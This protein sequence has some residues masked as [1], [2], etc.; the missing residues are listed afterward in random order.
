MPEPTQR[1]TVHG[2]DVQV[3]PDKDALGAAAAEFVAGRVREA[4]SARGEARVIFA[5]GASQYEFLAALLPAE[6]ITPAGAGYVPLT[7][8][9]AI[10][11]ALAALFGPESVDALPACPVA[12]RAATE[13][14][15]IAQHAFLGTRDDMDS[16]VASIRKVQR[17]WA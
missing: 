13:V 16:I 15:W 12:E 8:S 1:F 11:G 17:A 3:Y 7:R 6:G 9:P 4:L 5:T 14:V 10:R 2:I